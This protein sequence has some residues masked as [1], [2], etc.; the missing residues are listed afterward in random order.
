LLPS[1]EKVMPKRPRALAWGLRAL[2]LAGKAARRRPRT[3]AVV[4]G[5]VALAAAAGGFYAYALRQW[6]VAQAAVKDNRP[7]DAQSSLDLCLLVWPRSVP[8]HVLAARAAR[9]RG[10]FETADAHLNRCLKLE[11][12]ATEAVQVELLLMRVQRGEEDEVG[13]QLMERVKQG[14]PESALIL[15]TLAKAYMFYMRYG[16][17][18][19][20]LSQWGDLEPG[21]AEPWRWRGWVLERMGDSEAA[22]ADYQ[23][24]LE[25]DPGRVA[26]RLRLAEM[27]LE[28]SSLAEA[29]PHLELLAR[30]FPDRAD[31]MARLGQCRFAQGE[32][33]EARRLLERAVQEMPDDSAVLVHLAKLERQE[34]RPE[35]AEQWVRR[36]LKVDP[37]DTEAEFTLVNVLQDQGRWDEARAALEQHKKDTAM[38]KRVAVLLHDD[39]EHPSTDPD[40]LCEVG[41]L[42]LRSNPRV[43]LYWLH[44]ALALDPGHQATHKALAEYYEGKGDTEKAASHRR[45]LK[46]DGKAAP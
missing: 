8:V 42:F 24:V 26:I 10:D 31:V 7:D 44:R 34:G 12:G 18:Y 25:L 30:Q 32:H 45:R 27:Y 29:V 15:E 41:T 39:A 19:V 2:G 6:D 38:L 28:R 5:L 46:P 40:A 36:A 13:L 1:P 9:L 16:L 4:V 37:T 11:H 23:R 22:M 43:A 3:T 17:A 20:L 21:S 35:L 33:R 14:S